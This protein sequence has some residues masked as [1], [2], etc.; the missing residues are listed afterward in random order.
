MYETIDSVRGELAK[1]DS[2]IKRG[3]L[4]GAPT[5]EL[6]ERKTQVGARLVDLLEALADAKA[7]DERELAEL[8]AAGSEDIA[9]AAT[10]AIDDKLSS[11]AIPRHPKG[12][13]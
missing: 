1:I 8:I 2:E 11:L 12:I 13:E 7:E 10:R 9:S 6:R 3:V 5:A 4:E